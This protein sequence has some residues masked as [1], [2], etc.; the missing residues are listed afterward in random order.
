VASGPVVSEH[1]SGIDERIVKED[2]V[3]TGSPLINTSVRWPIPSVTTIYCKQMYQ[4][5][6]AK[7]P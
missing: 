2:L 5:G 4:D 1:A 3:P 6:F 7:G